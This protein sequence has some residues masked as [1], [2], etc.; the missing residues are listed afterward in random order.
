MKPSNELFVLI[1]S[2]TKSEKRFFKLSSAIQTGDKNYLKIFDFIE[3]QDVYNES[4]LKKN[5]K[6]ETFINHLPSE[7]N[8]LYKLILKSLRSFYSEQSIS[9]ILKEELKNIEILYNKALYKECRKFLKRAKKIATGSEK[10]Y[11]L[12]ELI[13][14]EKKLI[15]ELYESGN[16]NVNLDALIQEEETV[17]DKLRNLAE[18]QMLYSKINALFRSGGFTKNSD[19]RDAVAKIAD[20]QLIKGKNTAVSTRAATICYYIKGLCAATQRNYSDSYIFFNKTKSILDD[21]PKLKEDLAQRYLS[22]LFHLQRSY[23]DGAAYDKAQEMLNQIKQ[24]DGKKGFK[25]TDIIL[26]IKG[27]SFNEQ[28]I[29]NNHQGN[30]TSSVTQIEREQASIEVWR[31]QIS[32]ERNMQFYYNSAY[33]YFGYG[34]YKK[35]LFY[36]NNILNDNEQNLRQDIYNFT[37]ILNLIIHLELENYDYLDY[38]IK[39]TTRYLKKSERDYSVEHVLIK[40]IR[41]FIKNPELSVSTEAYKEMYEV[42]SELLIDHDERVILEYMDIKS[43]IYS[44]YRNCSMK[45]AIANVWQL[46]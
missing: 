23:V 44:K 27:I 40:Y 5:F 12:I 41:K 18:Y 46:A 9:S 28:L 20:H 4:E 22:T 11:Y 33:T 10:F 43:W 6:N 24:L 42:F 13:G 37:R 32:K 16:F 14:W 26:K 29:I 35:A 2:L 45:E 19:E 30:F 31:K 15:E 38:I 17:I 25:S 3:K 21:H 7:K 8:H 34:D 39:S 1:K 36:V